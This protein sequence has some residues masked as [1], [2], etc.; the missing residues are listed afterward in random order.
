MTL[1]HYERKGGRAPSQYEQLDISEDGAFRLW[2]TAGSDRVGAFAGTLDDAERAALAAEV[3]AADP[4]AAPPPARRPHALTEYLG[5]GTTTAVFDP[6]DEPAGPWGT[7]LT[8]LRRLLDELTAA[9]RAALEAA[10]DGDAHALTLRRLGDAPL[11]VD[12]DDGGV[13]VEVFGADQQLERTWQAPPLE[14][15]PLERAPG[16]EVRVP[17]LDGERLTPE[18][19]A[20]VRVTCE[21]TT[22][23]DTTPA[24]LTVVVGRGFPPV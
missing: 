4:E 21:L 13:T 15:G 11:H 22:D 16:V 19:T 10:V 7:L 5:A 14:D 23:D 2:R 17:L 12:F 8:R 20:I 6:Y 18:Q 3:A 1:V 24:A 9:P